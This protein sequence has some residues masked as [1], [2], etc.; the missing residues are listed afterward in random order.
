MAHLFVDRSLGIV[1]ARQSILRCK[2]VVY[3]RLNASDGP[4][5][6]VLTLVEKEGR[7][8][9]RNLPQQQQKF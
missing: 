4:T 8:E 3:I 7:P 1:K 6:R 9:I 2:R 5:R